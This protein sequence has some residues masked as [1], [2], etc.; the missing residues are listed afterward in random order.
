[1]PV[2]FF[3]FFAER[4]LL[5]IL[6]TCDVHIKLIRLSRLRDL[7]YFCLWLSS[8][9]QSQVLP[10][11]HLITSSFAPLRSFCTKGG[12]SP[13]VLGTSFYF[14]HQRW[15]RQHTDCL[16][17]AAKHC[18]D[19]HCSCDMGKPSTCSRSQTL[20]NRRW[21]VTQLSSRD[22]YPWKSSY[23]VGTRCMKVWWPP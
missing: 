23:P 14:L 20:T 16:L 9:P 13:A 15:H 5:Y 4:F 3:F 8:L 21:Q 2:D 17:M 6:Y 11:C 10:L 22:F 18:A 12:L 19:Q 1:M 7:F